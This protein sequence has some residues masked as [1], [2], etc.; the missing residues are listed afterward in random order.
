M[1]LRVL[2][3]LTVILAVTATAS[4][5]FTKVRVKYYGDVVNCSESSYQGSQTVD[6]NVCWIHN[7]TSWP[8]I[9]WNCTNT[10]ATC[11]ASKSFSTSDCTPGTEVAGHV[12]Y[13][14]ECKASALRTC[15]VSNSSAL[16]M[17]YWNC[18]DDTCS[19]CVKLTTAPVGK[20]PAQGGCIT[21][22]LPDLIAGKSVLINDIRECIALTH[23]WWSLPGCTTTD[24]AQVGG[25]LIPLTQCN[26]GWIFDCLP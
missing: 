17:T 4:P 15:D 19:S 20:T 3:L 11:I 1:Q 14:N 10:I 22:P 26:N 5:L 25:D 12:N 8:S 16:T 2:A 23:T 9:I 6:S 18:T 21:N 24:G 7:R 13:C